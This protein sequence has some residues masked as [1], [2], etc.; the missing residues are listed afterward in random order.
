M[1]REHNVAHR[2]LAWFSTMHRIRAI[3]FWSLS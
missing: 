2:M 1:T 3:A